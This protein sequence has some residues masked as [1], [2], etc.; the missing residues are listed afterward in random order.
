MGTEKKLFKDRINKTDTAILAKELLDA[1]DAGEN[2]LLKLLFGTA[3]PEAYSAHGSYKEGQHNRCGRMDKNTFTEKRLCKCLY[4][5]NGK[6]H[7]PEE[8]S[9]CAFQDR[10]D[11]IGDYVITDYEVP[12]YYYGKGI[13]AIDLI[14]SDGKKRYATEVKPYKGN[15]ETLLRMIGEIMT[16]TVGYPVGKYKKAIAFFENTKQEEEF[17][18]P[19]PE[20]TELLQK[21]N[22]T[23]FCFQKEER[24]TFRI[25]RL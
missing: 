24:K 13:G 4:Y 11:M 8:C 25:C 14:I 10:F 6:Y 20:I 1:M 18:N 9:K 23:I 22:I 3:Y 21:A 7:D 15:D 5:R 16:Y 2:V 12:A 17:E 19:A